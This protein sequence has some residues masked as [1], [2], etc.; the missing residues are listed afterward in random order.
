MLCVYFLYGFYYTGSIS[1]Q[2]GYKWIG[3]QKDCWL[4]KKSKIMW[5]FYAPPINI[6]CNH[7]RRLN[8]KI[9][10]N[11]GVGNERF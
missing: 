7:Q 6:H 5:D 3:S 9:Q 8:H 4:L 1:K 10:R 2:Q 11:G